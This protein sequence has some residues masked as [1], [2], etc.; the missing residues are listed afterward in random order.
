MSLVVSL[1]SS[2]HYYFSGFIFYYSVVVILFN[3]GI[4]QAFPLI[5]LVITVDRDRLM[6]RCA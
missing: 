6:G 5:G 4:L 1:S 3:I 2:I